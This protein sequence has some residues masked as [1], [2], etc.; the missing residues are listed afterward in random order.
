MEISIQ[1]PKTKSDA[2]VISNKPASKLK[3]FT[4][5]ELIVVI[6]I[7]AALMAI[8]AVSASGFV[9]DAKCETANQSA[10]IVYQ[11]FQ[12][13]LTDYEI[14]GDIFFPEYNDSSNPTKITKYPKSIKTDNGTTEQ[15]YTV[16]T[17][18]YAMASGESST[19]KSL[20]PVGSYDKNAYT[21]ITQMFEPGFEGAFV[22]YFDTFSYSVIYVLYT[23]A[24][25]PDTGAYYLDYLT[26][27]D[28]QCSDLADQRTMLKNDGVV[29][30]CYPYADAFN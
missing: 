4:L 21:E 17:S 25:D 22:I 5:V 13:L 28:S 16:Y 15:L 11:S 23:D 27:N 10:R 3:G 8:I 14:K 24:K 12:D 30:G 2:L 18:G 26:T 29:V 19:A 9:N 1:R 6:A 20:I 7:I